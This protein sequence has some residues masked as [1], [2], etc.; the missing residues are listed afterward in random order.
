MEFQVSSSCIRN[1]CNDNGVVNGTKGRL[2]QIVY[3]LGRMSLKIHDINK[4]HHYRLVWSL[5][6]QDGVISILNTNCDWTNGENTCQAIA[7]SCYTLTDY[8]CQGS[9]MSKA[10]VE[11]TIWQVDGY[12]ML[13]RVKSLDG[14]AI[15]RPLTWHSAILIEVMYRSTRYSTEEQ[16]SIAYH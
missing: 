12:V 5:L 16:A 3:E 10:I 4:S 6:H 9:T 15:L 11:P 13:S 2:K 14:L 1:A 7:N 8:K